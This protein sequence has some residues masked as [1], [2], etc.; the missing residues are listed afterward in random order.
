[1]GDYKTPG[2]LSLPA[3][4]IRAAHVIKG[5]HPNGKRYMEISGYLDCDVLKINCTASAPGAYDDG[6]QYDSVSYR[7][8]GKEPYSG[9]DANKHPTFKDYNEQAGNGIPVGTLTLV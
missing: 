3:G 5:V 7:N 9:V 8:C 6:G 2:A 4:G 1:M